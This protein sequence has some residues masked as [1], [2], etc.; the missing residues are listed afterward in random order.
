MLDRLRLNE[1][2]IESM[3]KGIEEVIELNDPVNIVLNEYQKDNGLLIKKVTVPFGVIAI[4]YE[5]R[6][7]VTS[8]VAALCL[9]SGNVS[10]LRSGRRILFFSD[11]VQALGKTG[12]DLK[13]SGIDGASFSAHKINGPRGVGLLYAK[14]HVKHY[15]APGR[16]SDKNKRS[17]RIAHSS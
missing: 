3:A 15:I 4:I 17:H 5:S 1:A 8:D 7:N 13:G 16:N 10:I 2:R 14:N 9:K 12:L 11:S 6:P